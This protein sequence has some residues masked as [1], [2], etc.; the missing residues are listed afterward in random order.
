MVHLISEANGKKSI[1]ISGLGSVLTRLPI[2]AIQKAFASFYYLPEDENHSV[3]FALEETISQ[4]EG[5][6]E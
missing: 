6:A 2:G 3:I 5:S 1:L 4:T